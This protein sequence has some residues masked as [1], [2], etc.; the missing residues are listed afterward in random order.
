MNAK[1]SLYPNAECSA[2]VS[3]FVVQ[4][5][6]PLHPDGG[7]HLYP[8]PLRGLHAR[9]WLSQMPGVINVV[10]RSEGDNY[11]YQVIILGEMSPR[12]QAEYA[13]LLRI[14]INF[15]GFSY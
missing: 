5:W 1:E 9:E 12:E 15:Y 14:A 4:I 3:G 10:E 13:S 6:F 8:K 2:S 11:G 7:D